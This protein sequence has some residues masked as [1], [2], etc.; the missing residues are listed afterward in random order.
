MLS[1]RT[2]LLTELNVRGIVRPPSDMLSIA[3]VAD[4]HEYLKTQRLWL[5]GHWTAY[6]RETDLTTEQFLIDPDYSHALG[7]Y[8][9]DVAAHCPHITEKALQYAD[10]AK[11]YLHGEARLFSVNLFWSFPGGPVKPEIQ[12]WHRDRATFDDKQ[13][14]IY[15]YLT[16]V[17]FYEAHGYMPGSHLYDDAAPRTPGAEYIVGQAGTYFIENPYGF[18]KGRKP[19]DRCRLLAWARF[20]IL[21]P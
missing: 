15:F 19:S 21:V 14:A 13:F 1:S 2:D 5:G 7:C 16:D 8:S 3:Q 17:D 11:E 6:A 20:G 12:E 9:A 10:L 4:I 18:H